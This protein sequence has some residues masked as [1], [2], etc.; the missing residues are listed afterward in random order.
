MKR[1]LDA[2]LSRGAALMA[3]A[4]AAVSGATAG[5]P[6]P[7]LS[8][9]LAASRLAHRESRLRLVLTVLRGRVRELEHHGERV[10]EGLLEATK[11]FQQDLADVCARAA[12]LDARL[13]EPRRDIAHCA[14]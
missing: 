2:A 11:G 4:P 8:D 1:S 13:A 6:A 5:G 3:V 12:E 10:P 14:F 9:R 7:T